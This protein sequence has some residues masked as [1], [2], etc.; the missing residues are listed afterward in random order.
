MST[1]GVV[2]SIYIAPAAASPMTAV[3]TISAIAG[4]GLEGDRYNA[5]IGTYSNHPGTGRGVTLIELEAL[6]ALQREYGV[7][8]TSEQTRRNLVTR[9]VYLNHL[10]DREFAVGNAVLR[11]MRL[12]EPCL[13]LERLSVA[14]VMCGLIHRGGLRADIVRS[15]TIHE[16]DSITVLPPT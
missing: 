6:V 10:V 7:V 13:H 1:A 4:Q 2:C 5:S 9:G 8:I 14:G 12:C 3:E 16:G 11:G 15:G